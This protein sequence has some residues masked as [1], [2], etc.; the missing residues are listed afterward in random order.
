MISSARLPYQVALRPAWKGNILFVLAVT[1]IVGASL[2]FSLLLG[3]PVACLT[4]HHYGAATALLESFKVPCLARLP[5][6]RTTM[7]SPFER[8]APGPAQLIRR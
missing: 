4:L 7:K 5:V 6:E 2:L 3:S 8:M 1:M